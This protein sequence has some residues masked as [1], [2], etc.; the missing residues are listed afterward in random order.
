MI[1][2]S[3]Q[4][5][6]S[7]LFINNNQQLFTN[8]GS[9]AADMA[10]NLFTFLAMRFSASFGPAPGVCSPRGIFFLPSLIQSVGL[11]CTGLLNV[12][13]PVN[14]TMDGN[15]VVVAATINTQSLQQILAGVCRSTALGVSI[16]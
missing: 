9:P 8:A 15:G 7:G 3:Q 1:S 12:M 2:C 14:L 10:N 4:F 16:S 6:Q 11:G 13:N 5:A